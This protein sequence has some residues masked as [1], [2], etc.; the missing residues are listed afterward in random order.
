ML[1]GEQEGC[2]ISSLDQAA[3]YSSFLQLIMWRGEVGGTFFI[4]I[5]HLVAEETEESVHFEREGGAWPSL[6]EGL[7]VRIVGMDLAALRRFGE[8]A[9]RENS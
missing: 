6:K 4:G 9:K 1:G 2:H 7:V 8:Y 3:S 5:F